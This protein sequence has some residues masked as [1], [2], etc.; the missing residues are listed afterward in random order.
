VSFDLYQTKRLLI[1]RGAD[2]DIQDIDG[3]TALHHAFQGL[4][5]TRSCGN[6]RRCV[7]YLVAAGADVSI[8]DSDGYRSIDFAQAFWGLP[9]YMEWAAL[10]REDVQR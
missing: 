7:K 1:D 8:P 6:F 2:L 9:Q 3:R 5:V 10:H 4:N